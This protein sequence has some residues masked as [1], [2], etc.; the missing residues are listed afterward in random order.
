MSQNIMRQIGWQTLCRHLQYSCIFFQTPKPL[1][2]FFYPK[3]FVVH[4][5][6]CTEM[7]TATVYLLVFSLFILL[8]ISYMQMATVT[9]YE[10]SSFHSLCH[11]VKMPT[12]YMY[13]FIFTSSICIYI[14][15]WHQSLLMSK[16][17]SGGNNNSILADS[18]TVSIHLC[19]CAVMATMTVHLLIPH[20]ACLLMGTVWWWQH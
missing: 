5:P 4:C 20:I 3:G 6:V 19:H 12:M 16:L 10:L 13:V 2:T 1:L 18:H 9:K 15:I 7:A 17:C 11:C 14:W 8:C